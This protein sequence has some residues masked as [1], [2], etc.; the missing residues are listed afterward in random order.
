MLSFRFLFVLFSLTTASFA[1]AQQLSGDTH[2]ASLGKIVFPNSCAPAAQTP[3]LKG[4]ALLH[5][6]QY[7]ASEKSF[8]DATQA[9]PQCAIAYW[10]LAMT[11]YHPLWEGAGPKA[12]VAGRAELQKIR[13]EWPVTKRERE[14]IDAAG[15]IFSDTSRLNKDRL[16]SYNRA[17]ADLYKQYP[18]DGEAGAFYAL[19]LLAL[20]S[21]GDNARK[22]A[23]SILN[24]LT[25]AQPE[26]P[27][28]VHYLIHAADTPELAPQGLEAARRYAKIAPDSSHALH[29]PS[30]IF[31]RLGLWQE[32]IDSNQAAAVAAAEATQQ[33]M[34]EAHY[35]FHAMDYLNYSYLQ[36]GEEAKARQIVEDIDKV[37][38]RTDHEAENMRTNF[39]AR[40]LLELHHWKE[41][42]ALM[43]VGNAFNQE[44][45]YAVRAI[46]AA[47]TGD[48]KAAEENFKSVKKAAKNIHNKSERLETY[49]EEAEAWI[50]FAKG[51]SDKALKQ[52]RALADQQDREDSEG[53]TVPAREMLADMLLELHQPAKAL[54]EYEASLKLAP[55]RFNGLYGAA[56]AAKA[57][58]DANKANTY[59]SKL[60][61]SCAPQAD[62]E[63]LQHT[64]VVAA[65][66]Q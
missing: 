40:N 63:E 21:G 62:R 39:I 30:H 27:G 57:A 65:G 20:P 46:A 10:G 31:V 50:A 66:S 19:S 38:G 49:P 34:G 17:M 59:Y 24:R 25:A 48:K 52:M 15:I 13:K 60:H 56:V 1:P 3:F 26:H 47:R 61:E 14:Y 4:M 58:G 28:A 22:E 23:I 44:K 11:H 8:A 5:S 35:Q 6:F 64:S 37:P 33:H 7:A 45:I 16:E 54:T 2:P 18:E 32:S 55:N 9:D 51:K 53:F 43:P 42:L 29:M 41:A 36:R 12:L